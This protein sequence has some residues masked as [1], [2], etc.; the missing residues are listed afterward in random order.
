MRLLSLLFWLLTP[1]SLLQAAAG[2]PNII[3]HFIDDLG[4]GDIGPFGAVKQKTPHL[5]RMARE[6]MKLTTT[7]DQTQTA[8]VSRC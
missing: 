6:G 2:A 4:Y 8:R 3:I 1:C 7:S 5:D